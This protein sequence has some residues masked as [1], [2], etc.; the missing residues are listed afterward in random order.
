M[1]MKTYD[2]R[3]D[4]WLQYS[5]ILTGSEE[6]LKLLE[7]FFHVKI[8]NSPEGTAITAEDEDDIRAFM[9]FIE[10]LSKTLRGGETVKTEDLERF[11]SSFRQYGKLVLGNVITLNAQGK[12]I[13]PKTKGQELFVDA[14]GKKDLV[15]AVGP[16]GT[17]KTFL[18]VT[19]GVALLKEKAVQRLVISR[20]I[21]EAGEKIG[22][23]PGD[24]YQ[25]VDPFFRPLYDALFELMGPEKTQR[26]IERGIIEVAPL[27]YMRGRT[28]DNAFIILD[29]AQNTG[30]EQMKMFL[31]RMGL[32]SKMVVTGDITQIDLP[33]PKESGLIRALDILKGFPEISIVRLSESDIVR[34]RLVQK[35]V[36]AYEDYEEQNPL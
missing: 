25:K 2:F 26:Y 1:G 30:N 13:R 36:R 32:G 19:Y 10:S 5:P 12:P 23:L 24:I 35:I 16:A 11:L 6:Q 14:M 29:E 28:F 7:N 33:K 31:T 15:F 34:H 17:G 9:D 4:E 18:A 20:P 8:V 3:E 21:L 27:A 22:F